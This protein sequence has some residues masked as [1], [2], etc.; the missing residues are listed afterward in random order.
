MIKK[1]EKQIILIGLVFTIA[2]ALAVVV[3]TW[4]VYSNE[5]LYTRMLEYLYD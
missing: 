3:L 4:V 2:S 5:G 1:Y